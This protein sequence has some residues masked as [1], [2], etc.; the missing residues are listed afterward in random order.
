VNDEINGFQVQEIGL[1][2]VRL[3]DTN[4]QVVILKDQTGMT[5]QDGG[6]WI[7]VSAPAYYSPGAQRRTRL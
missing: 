6:P 1:F 5:R 2:E 4:H 3:M 7:R